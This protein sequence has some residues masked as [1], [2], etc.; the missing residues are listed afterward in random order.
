MEERLPSGTV[1]FLLTDLEGSTRLWEAHPA[2][3]RAAMARHDQILEEAIGSNRGVIFSR[4]GD[5][6]AAAFATPRDAVV[7]ATS[8]QRALAAEPWGDV[9][10][11]R[12]RVG[13]HTDEGLV[14]EG[15]YANQPVNRCARLMAVAHGGQVVISA[16]TEQL[17]RGLL[18]PDVGMVDLG[19]HRLRD[20]GRA[21]RVYQLTHPD[22]QAEFPPLRSLDVLPGNLP[23]Q[24]SSFIGREALTARVAATLTE[25]RVV[26]LTGVGG[27]GKTRLA[28]QVAAEVLP[29]F[30]EGAWLVELAPI[31]DPATI[32]DAV[33]A[34]FRLSARPGQTLEESL[35]ESLATKQLLL[36]LDNCEHVLGAVARLV[37]KIER[38]CPG[39][40]VL[41]TS[42]EGMAI[43]GEQLL[44][45]PSLDAGEPGDQ[46]ER[47]TQTDAVRLFVERARTVRADFA[48]TP[49]NASAIVEVCQRLDGVPLAIE[50][51]AARAIAL[52]PSELARR[53]D[54]R[55][56]VLAG[57][58]RGAVE[59][60]ATLRAAIDWSYELLSEPEQLLLARLAVFAGGC[61]LEAAEEICSG[62][63]VEPEAV[64]DLV[65]SL[66]ARSLV[67]AEADDTGTRYRLLETIRQYGEER[68]TAREETDS[69]RKRHAEFYVGYAKRADEHLYGPDQ[70]VWAKQ[71]SAE[72]DNVYTAF[73]HA[74]DTDDADLAA[75]LVSSQPRVG[76]RYGEQRLLPAERVLSLAGIEDSPWYP[77]ALIRAAGQAVFGGDHA[78]GLEYRQRALD[79]LAEGLPERAGVRSLAAEIMGATMLG[80]GRFSETAEAYAEAAEFAREDKGFGLAAV[81]MAWGVNTRL[82]AGESG[83]AVRTMAEEAV[84]AARRADMPGAIAVALISLSLSFIDSDPARGRALL[85]ESLVRAGQPGNEFAL[86]IVPAALAAGRLEDW[87]LTLALAGRTLRLYRFAMAN[88]GAATALAELARAFAASAPEVAGV[89]HGAARAEF[90][91]ANPDAAKAAR[92]DSQRND[93]NRNFVLRALH[94]TGTI[95]AEALGVERWHELRATGLAMNTDEAVS[96][97]LDHVDP[98]LLTGPLPL[99]QPA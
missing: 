88:I 93:S 87:N 80:A 57:G 77:H 91:R 17:V 11:L 62:G 99:G 44:A 18:P 68:L 39:V 75:R 4:M 83:E 28:L 23:T 94:E 58:R 89:L 43:E 14:V 69:L 45:V 60:H 55:F 2:A 26:T 59:R 73:S 7:A 92:S 48:L 53:L 51:A 49:A 37:T 47:L 63:P 90:A 46:L 56:Q 76:V 24:M 86:A 38:S 70:I 30:R 42:R 34:S 15:R 82:L 65:A 81:Y 27:V 41:A 29:R 85:V 5:G 19:E 10:H 61:T 3:M 79:V 33:T 64:F 25:S 16:G 74:I 71:L 96:F 21:T 13:V 6:M 95:V 32:V 20:L 52:T 22:L 12:A 35:I 84:S 36:V 9:G 66:V 54:R 8:M 67:V 50:L 31:R 40:V 72:W 97:A 78:R 1:T 98:K